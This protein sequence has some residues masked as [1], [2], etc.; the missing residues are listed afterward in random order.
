[1]NLFVLKNITT[2]FEFIAAAVTE[3]SFPIVIYFSMLHLSPSSLPT[4][5]YQLRLEH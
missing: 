4:L 3:E 2:Y 1:M 5:Y